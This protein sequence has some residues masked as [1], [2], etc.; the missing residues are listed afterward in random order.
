MIFQ[1]HSCFFVF[2]LL[3]Y[4]IF[5]SL[6]FNIYSILYFSNPKFLLYCSLIDSFVHPPFIA[7][8]FSLT[9]IIALL[10][11]LLPANSDAFLL[12]LVYMIFK[13]EYPCCFVT[14]TSILLV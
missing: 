3:M 13:A 10:K 2:T 4:K 12:A 11:S 1:N 6:H 9:R 8:F 7:L 5:T 14:P